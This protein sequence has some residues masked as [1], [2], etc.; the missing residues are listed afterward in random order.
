MPY[1]VAWPSREF[2]FLCLL[3]AWV[4]LSLYAYWS[5]H[6]LL[7]NVAV[8]FLLGILGILVTVFEDWSKENRIPAIIA[9]TLLGLTGVG[10]AYVQTQSDD[11]DRQYALKLQESTLQ[12]QALAWKQQDRIARGTIALQERLFAATSE[13]KRLSREAINT[14]TGDGGYCSVTG[15]LPDDKSI[16]LVVACSSKYPIYDLH[17]AMTDMDH[18][19]SEDALAIYQQRPTF[20]I[21]MIFQ[22]AQT[23]GRIA[24]EGRDTRSLNFSFS[25]RNGNWHQ[26]LRLKKVNGDWCQ[27]SRAERETRVG[28]QIKYVKIEEWGQPCFSAPATN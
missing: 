26:T 7:L 8:Q 12:R 21:P 28:R 14:M 25:A 13:I 1:R 17:I 18:W 24:L 5:D 6:L 10:V 22:T 4:Y 19:S 15:T 3:F 23:L 2:T 27:A 9:F 11:A 16:G 20:N